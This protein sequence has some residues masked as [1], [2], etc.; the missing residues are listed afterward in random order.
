MPN[1][2]PSTV[3]KTGFAVLRAHSRTTLGLLFCW[4]TMACSGT[5]AVP[6]GTISVEGGPG[7]DVNRTRVVISGVPF[8]I[9]LYVDYGSDGHREASFVSAELIPEQPLVGAPIPLEAIKPLEAGTF[10][11]FV[12]RGLEVGSYSLQV[13]DAKGRA[14]D[15]LRAAFTIISGACAQMID[16]NTCDADCQLSLGCSCN[17]LGVCEA[18]CGD[19]IIRTLDG[20]SCD[21]RNKQPGDG[22]SATCEQETSTPCEAQPNGCVESALKAIPDRLTDPKVGTNGQVAYHS[23]ISSEN[24]EAL[25]SLEATT[26]APWLSVEFLTDGNDPNRRVARLLANTGGLAPGSYAATATISSSV[27]GSKATAIGIRIVVVD[28]FHLGPSLE[29]CPHPIGLNSTSSTC[30]LVGESALRRAESMSN[31]GPVHW[32]LHDDKRDPMVRKAATYHGGI[33]LNGPRR[34]GAAYGV[35]IE[36]V[37]VV[38]GENVTGTIDSSILLKED[39]S[40]IERLTFINR[41]GCNHAIS[42]WEKIDDPSS[43]SEDHIIENIR[44]NASTPEV[45]RVNRTEQPFRIGRNTIVRNSHFWGYWEGSIDLQQARGAQVTGNT[46]VHYELMQGFNIEG[47]EDLRITNNVVAS[48]ARTEPTLFVGD[49]RT[50]GALLAGNVYEG[51]SSTQT[52][53]DLMFGGNQVD[54][55]QNELELDSPLEPFFLSGAQTTAVRTNSVRGMSLD[56]HFLQGRSDLVPGAYQRRSPRTTRRTK[57]LVGD[58]VCGKTACDVLASADDEIQ[59]AVWTAWPDSEIVVFP[60]A[61]PYTGNAV[62]SWPVTIR[63]NGAQPEDVTLQSNEED[64]DRVN[65]LHWVHNSILTVLT[66]CAGAVEIE[67]L[68]L[69]VDSGQWSDSRAVYIENSDLPRRLRR[70]SRLR[71]ESI[72]SS[73]SSGLDQGLYLGNNVIAQDI[74]VHGAFRHCASFLDT[75]WTKNGLG[76]VSGWNL[77]LTCRLTSNGVFG[78]SSIFELP[79]NGPRAFMN[80]IAASSSPVPAFSAPSGSPAF[81]FARAMSVVGLNDSLCAGLDCSD[82]G[83]STVTIDAM[84]DGNRL[85]VSDTDSHLN[86]A[87]NPPGIDAGKS[88]DCANSNEDPFC[89]EPSLSLGESLDGIPRTTPGVVVDRGAYEQ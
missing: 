55:N 60:S 20:E 40:H 6:P 29:S 42:A 88:P 89:L 7:S 37:I 63:G 56:G 45:S 22:C 83:N 46:F 31:S 39:R 66:S 75:L 69:V 43:S 79:R 51:Y 12:P 21:D 41:I 74:L 58:S 52:G 53:L 44:A 8:Q 28:S 27:M 86:P 24:R 17:T 82:S 80:I 36:N 18:V 26:T 16:P 3:P 64:E 23:S 61:Q 14:A 76:T 5:K 50:N 33:E 72:V 68:R 70:L 25:L 32:F 13:K 38:C 67:N 1:P 78:A 87:T 57:V 34:L 77:N 49:D 81:L 2:H 48:L 11:A 15:M 71:I 47:A 10:E 30:D 73:T 4:A 19:G 62:I 54:S 85:F 9:D 59:I 84:S 35:P 65:N